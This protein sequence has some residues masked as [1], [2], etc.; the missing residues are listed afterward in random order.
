MGVCCCAA[1]RPDAHPEVASFDHYGPLHSGEAVRHAR[2]IIDSSVLKWPDR[3]HVEHCV[4][5]WAAE[6]A[7]VRPDLLRV[8][9]F[10]CC[11]RGDSG[12]G[13]DLDL[14]KESGR[15]ARALAQETVWVYPVASEAHSTVDTKAD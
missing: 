12:V 5:Q 11:A 4:R 7:A 15:F 2:E 9:Y 6:L 13:S 14:V 8:G 3:D 10:G 1:G